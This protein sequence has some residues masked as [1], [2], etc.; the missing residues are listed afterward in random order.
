MR[1]SKSKRLASCACE[2]ETARPEAK[3]PEVRTLPGE[4]RDL[5]RLGEPME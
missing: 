2:G 4:E 1:E 3:Q 5:F